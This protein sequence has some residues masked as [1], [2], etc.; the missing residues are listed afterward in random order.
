MLLL[1]CKRRDS[2]V[3]CAVTSRFLTGRDWKL[4]FVSVTEWSKPSMIAC[5][6]GALTGGLARIEDLHRTVEEPERI[7]D[8]QQ[9]IEVAVSHSRAINFDTTLLLRPCRSDTCRA[10]VVEDGRT[11]RS[12]FVMGQSEALA[13]FSITTR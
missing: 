11:Q 5:S 1:A 2:L 8:S 10:V 4:T 6:R 13:P 3:T 7:W 12:G 9:L